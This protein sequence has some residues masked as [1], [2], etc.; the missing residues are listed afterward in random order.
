MENPRVL[1]VDDEPGVRAV[2]QKTLATEEYN[3]EQAADGCEAIRKLDAA[4]YDVLLVDLKMMPVDGLQVINA[5]RAKGSDAAVIILTA[6]STIETAVEA[7][8]L[9]AFDY[10]FKPAAPEVIRKRVREAVHYS[11]Q[12][13]RRS[14]LLGQVESLRQSLID[15]DADAGPE[16]QAVA[17]DRFLRSGKLVIDK[18]HRS[19]MLDSSVLDLTTAE[20][21]LLEALVEA[22][23]ET[24]APRELAR[25]ALHY[26]PQEMEA[27]Q[28]V[29]YH[30]HQLRRKLGDDTRS[31]KYIKTVRYKGYFWGD[32]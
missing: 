2:L 31:P 20:F 1:I 25:R 5:L 29:K 21:D 22:S 23:P 16:R 30:V 11:R 9:G 7:L 28:T 32:G 13:T 12:V 10:L 4:E 17:P 6:H 26:D 24:I 3:L 15:L 14:R 8:R 18:Y 27:R 19:A